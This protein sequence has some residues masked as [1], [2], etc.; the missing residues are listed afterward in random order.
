MLTIKCKSKDCSWKQDACIPN[1]SANMVTSQRALDLNNTCTGINHL[2]MH[3]LQKN[4]LLCINFMNSPSVIQMRSY[5]IHDKKKASTFH[6]CKVGNPKNVPK[7]GSTR[8]LK[9]YIASFHVLLAN[10]K[11]KSKQYSSLALKLTSIFSWQPHNATG[12]V[13]DLQKTFIT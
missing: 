5:K 3:K 1:D 11:T 6:T 10:Q 7:W 12:L 8:V 4:R 2:N 13:V 9:K